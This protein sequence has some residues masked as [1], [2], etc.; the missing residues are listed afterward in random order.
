[1]FMVTVRSPDIPLNVFTADYTGAYVERAIC[2]YAAY[3]RGFFGFSGA[4]LHMTYIHTR[5]TF[6]SRDAS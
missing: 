1:M 6:T 2:V 5:R 3:D 4:Q